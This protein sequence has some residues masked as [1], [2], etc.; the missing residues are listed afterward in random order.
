MDDSDQESDELESEVHPSTTQDSDGED[1]IDSED[2][3][4]DSDADSINY[5]DA[6]SDDDDEKIGNWKKSKS[7]VYVEKEA[8]QNKKKFASKEERERSL[9][10]KI[11]DEKAEVAQVLASTKSRSD[12]LSTSDLLGDFQVEEDEEADNQDEDGDNEETDG[13]LNNQEKMKIIRKESPE[14]VEL[15]EELK[16]NLKSIRSQLHPLMTKFVSHFLNFG[17]EV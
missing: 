8:Q 7:G 1:G 6:D 2:L 11:D 5:S 3:E 10:Q 9:L 4:D 17:F 12:R 15:V 16:K 14:L 13:S